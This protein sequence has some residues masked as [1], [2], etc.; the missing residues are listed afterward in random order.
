VET[1]LWEA[2]QE[3]FYGYRFYETE[4]TAT[5][6]LNGSVSS[7]VSS[8]LLT[9]VASD[10]K[11]IFSIRDTTNGR[12]LKKAYFRW[13]DQRNILSGTPTNYAR[14]GTDILFDAGAISAVSYRL[15]YR[16]QITEPVFTGSVF[17]ETPAEWDEAIRFKAVARGFNALFE[18]E[19][20][21]FYD[22]S[23]M[24]LI[25]S[26][27]SDEVIEAEDDDFGI[28]VRVDFTGGSQRR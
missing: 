4:K 28:G 3:V 7:P 2:Y 18:Y 17:P 22:S 1:W 6:I 20:A 11:H 15:R 26:L 13:L 27:P 21:S 23:A 19:L 9:N 5:F 14:Y 8:I 25:A 16:K 12:K 10:I 24:K